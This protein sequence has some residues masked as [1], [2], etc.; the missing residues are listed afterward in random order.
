MIQ[1]KMKQ[2]SPHVCSFYLSFLP[3][4][5]KNYLAFN[6]FSSFPFSSFLMELSTTGK[7]TYSFI[8]TSQLSICI[9][10]CT[11]RIE[12]DVIK[13]STLRTFL[14]IS[15]LLELFGIKTAPLGSSVSSNPKKRFSSQN[16]PSKQL[17]IAS[18]VPHFIFHKHIINLHNHTPDK[19]THTSV[20]DTYSTDNNFPL[21]WAQAFH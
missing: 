1:Q 19:Q 15:L 20:M 5:L 11:V 7:Y 12:N 10:S 3:N 9:L 17:K 16:R 4:N 21:N 6:S 14:Y 13:K 8:C 2:R 18:L